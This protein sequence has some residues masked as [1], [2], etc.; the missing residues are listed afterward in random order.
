VHWNRDW[1]GLCLLA[2]GHAAQ[3][4]KADIVI[5]AEIEAI[6]LFNE[7]LNPFD[8]NTTTQDGVVTLEG[9]VEDTR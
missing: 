5:T 6:Y 9:T 8:I 2:V 1:F 7:W 3:A 4:D